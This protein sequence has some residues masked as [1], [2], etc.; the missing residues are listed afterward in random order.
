[1][2]FSTTTHGSFTHDPAPTPLPKTLAE[3]SPWVWVQ[4]CRMA[5]EKRVTDDV[6][7]W[8]H[9]VRCSCPCSFCFSVWV[10]FLFCFFWTNIAF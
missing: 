8:E 6:N 10:L 3:P 4:V 1:M 5:R 2:F 7:G 9:R